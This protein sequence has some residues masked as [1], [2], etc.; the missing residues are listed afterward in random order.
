M[1]SLAHWGN[2][3]VTGRGLIALAGQGSI[4]EINLN[5][6]EKYVVHPRYGLFPTFITLLTRKL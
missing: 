5:A 1:K 6:G 2:S 3:E 4:Y